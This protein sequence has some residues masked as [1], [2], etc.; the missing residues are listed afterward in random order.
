MKDGWDTNNGRYIRLSLIYLCRSHKECHMSWDRSWAFSK[1]SLSTKMIA[2]KVSEVAALYVGV[3][4]E[5]EKEAD[6]CTTIFFFVPEQ[7]QVQPKTIEI[8]IYHMGKNNYIISLEADASDNKL[9][10]DADQLAEDI[11]EAF[12]AE[13][14]E[15]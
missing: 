15:E 6:D 13:Q 4:A 11:A 2:Q 8:S 5:V 7:E 3:T 14:F 12:Q 1:K 9:S 10:E